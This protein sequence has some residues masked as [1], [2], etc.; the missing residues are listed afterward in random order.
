VHDWV[1]CFGFMFHVPAELPPEGEAA[2]TA[3]TPLFEGTAAMSLEYRAAV[4][5]GT[6]PVDLTYG[7][8]TAR[9][10]VAI[11]LHAAALC[12]KHG[13]APRRAFCDIGSGLGK[14]VIAASVAMPSLR[15]ARGVEVAA[16]AAAVAQSVL[17]DYAGLLRSDCVVTMDCADAT[18]DVRAPCAMPCQR[19]AV[20]HARVLCAQQSWTTSDVV[21]SYWNAI[22]G[23]TRCAIAAAACAMAVG[24]VVI[25]TRVPLSACCDGGHPACARTLVSSSWRG[26][27]SLTMVVVPCPS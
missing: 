18:V 8:V 1:N 4:E 27:W 7:E 21:Y 17:R 12:A 26:Q 3:L 24:S 6:G 22:P 11:L 20:T 14:A 13:L 19:P 23:P 5:E 15:A 25:T 9:G 10:C 2:V 16:S